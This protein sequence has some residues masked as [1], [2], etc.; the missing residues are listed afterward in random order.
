MNPNESQSAKKKREERKKR[1]T[2]LGV[3]F[4][5]SES[6]ADAAKTKEEESKKRA[7]DREKMLLASLVVKKEDQGKSKSSKKE[8]APEKKPVTDETLKAALSPDI[9]QEIPRVVDGELKVQHTIEKSAEKPKEQKE[10][11]EAKTDDEE[12]PLLPEQRQPLGS[13]NVGEVLNL[14]GKKSLEEGVI[15]LRSAQPERV[16]P[17][18]RKPADVEMLTP[19]EQPVPQRMERVQPEASVPPQE[20]PEE[21]VEPESAP[22][23]GAHEA[24]PE[25]V[26][27]AGG[28]GEAPPV[29]PPFPPVPS[30]E[31]PG[32][33]DPEP[34]H[35][36]TGPHE[37]PAL[38][39]FDPAGSFRAA[40]ARDAVAHR[41]GEEL[42][43]TR[44][45]LED[46]EYYGAKRASGYNT[47]TALLAYLYGRHRGRKGERRKAEKRYTAL[48]KKLNEARQSYE[49]TQNEQDKRNIRNEAQLATTERK[50]NDAER[51]FRTYSTEQKTE[52][53][54]RPNQGANQAPN[55]QPEA[56]P[57]PVDP[58]NPDQLMIAPENTLQTSAWLAMEVN[59]KT[60]RLAENQSIQYGREYHSERAKETRPLTQ[61]HTAVAGEVALV[62][63]ATATSGQN[64]QKQAFGSGSSSAGGGGGGGTS[65]P[66]QIPNASMQGAPSDVRSVQ[67]TALPVS[68]Q[69]PTQ[70]SD[71]PIALWPWLVA[72]AFV[73]LCLAVLLR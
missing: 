48:D 51:R 6:E 29:E 12:Y 39:P 42:V 52:Q 50:L 21:P 31:F 17:R 22:A 65:L 28:G 57:V 7:G 10:S 59:A 63:A 16:V 71:T 13:L 33:P 20:S 66:S 18:Q 56:V 44:R 32:G 1:A 72:L 3:L 2:G 53:N 64:G 30:F 41:G 60:G 62:A 4:V 27:A 19:Q 69:Q 8:K 68:Q 14:R 25:P 67:K 26:P 35:R 46:A 38:S 36:S 34:F 24:E 40:A 23:A 58:T 43:A 70:K 11:K 54:Q 5:P 55:R 15:S 47:A 73:A 37:A 61:K 9:A 49:F 45:E